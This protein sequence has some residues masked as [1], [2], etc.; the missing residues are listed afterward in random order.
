MQT[1]LIRKTGIL[2]LTAL[3][4]LKAGAISA[5][6]VTITVTGHVRAQ[7][8]TIVT[9]TA[10]VDLGVMTASSMS[11]ANA[12][13]AWKDVSLN[14][15]QCPIGTSQVTAT[16]SGT[17]DSTGNYFLNAG[18]AGNIAIQLAD[19]NGNNLKNRDTLTRPVGETSM[20][21]QFALRV[22]AI[23]PTGGATRGTISSI[24]NVTYTWL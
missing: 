14:L 6:D 15:I 17:S 2:G 23:S 16:F 20:S 3:L 10:E 18:D 9:P 11:T 12:T 1:H 19:S 7:P 5:A 8:C 24:I 22:R 13:S 4:F 21:T